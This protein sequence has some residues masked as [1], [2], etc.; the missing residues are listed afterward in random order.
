MM[1]RNATIVSCSILLCKS[2]KKVIFSLQISS[3]STGQRPRPS[4]S[5]DKHP[6]QSICP[7]GAFKSSQKIKIK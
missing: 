2:S 3:L 6:K 7:Q 5:L 1:N 4:I